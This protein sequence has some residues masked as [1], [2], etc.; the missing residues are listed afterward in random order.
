MVLNVHPGNWI[1]A[2]QVAD[3]VADDYDVF[4]PWEIGLDMHRSREM[5][6]LLGEEGSGLPVKLLSQTG[7]MM[8]AATERIQALVE[9]G[10]LRHNGDKISR[11]AAANCE[12]KYDPFNFPK[13]QTH[14]TC[15][16]YT[17][18]SPRD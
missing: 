9:A 6:R 7:K 17:S 3:Q 2:G 14:P 13:H 10:K 12:V 18:P 4:T 1:D 16:L 5:N 11:W 8:Q 15:L